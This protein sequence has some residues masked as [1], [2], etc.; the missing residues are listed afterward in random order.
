MSHVSI[1]YALPFST[2]HL[3]FLN[4]SFAFWT[5]IQYIYIYNIQY[6]WMYNPNLRRSIL[7]KMSCKKKKLIQFVKLMTQVTSRANHV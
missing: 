1:V 3:L 6:M 2:P 5:Y 4:L 7:E